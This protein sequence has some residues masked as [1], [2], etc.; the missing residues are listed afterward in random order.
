MILDKLLEK[1]DVIAYI[2]LRIDK[3]NSDFDV[4]KYPPKEREMQR[5]RITGRCR[6]LKRLK[7]L[8]SQDS[9][10]DASKKMFQERK[11]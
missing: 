5:Q 3:L 2:D 8:I 4:R 7:K 9:L 1:K 10:K 11:P 6:E